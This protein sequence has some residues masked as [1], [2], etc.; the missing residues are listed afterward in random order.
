[1]TADDSTLGVTAVTMRTSDV[2]L[3]IDPA[4]TPGQTVTLAYTPGTNPVRDQ[5]QN[6][7]IALTNLTVQKQHSGP[8][9]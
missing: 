6:P 2:E 9:S 7:A 5:A 3:T 8:D 1:M 4:V